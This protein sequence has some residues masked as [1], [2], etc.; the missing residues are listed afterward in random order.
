MLLTFRCDV[1]ERHAELVLTTL[2]TMPP[3]GVTE[4]QVA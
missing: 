4:L 3:R 2:E 1:L